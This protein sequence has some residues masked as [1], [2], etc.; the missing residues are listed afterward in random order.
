MKAI[1]FLMVGTCPLM[2]NNPQTVNP[3]NEFSK[4]LKAVTSKR[5]KTD[6][7]LDEIFHLHFLASC[8]RNN[9]GQYILPANMVFKSFESG[10]KEFKLGQKFQR[11][12][13]VLSDLLLKFP[14]NGCTPEELW[15]NHGE[16]YVDI[17][18][19]GIMKSKVPTAR[20]IVPEWSC[21]GELHFDEN[22][23]NK[24]EVW[25]ALNAAGVRYGVGTY[26]QH[27]G[28]YN[29]TEIK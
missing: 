5:T 19:V 1:K 3:M 2:L 26:R 7:D 8:Y 13:F 17:R 11:S 22:Q 14:E 4:A 16:K 6:E 28:R 24:S 18:P 15:K 23:L 25:N 29:I 10:A 27:Y 12:L 9:K 21:E 20:M